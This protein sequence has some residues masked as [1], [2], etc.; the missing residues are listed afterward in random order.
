MPSPLETDTRKGLSAE[1]NQSNKITKIETFRVPPRWL[2][3]RVET[4]Q[5]IVGWGEATLEGHGEAVE[6][7]IEDFKER[8][9]GWEA[10]NIED[11]CKCSYYLNPL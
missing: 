9:I 2:F 3:I 4:E 1:A 11:I 7:A 5:G 6:G 10:S 8:F